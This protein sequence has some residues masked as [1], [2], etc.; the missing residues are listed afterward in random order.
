MQT[1]ANNM[2]SQQNKIT[3]NTTMVALV[4]ISGKVSKILF[5]ISIANISEKQ[6]F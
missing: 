1:N 5:R 3:E 4:S 2:H 6:K